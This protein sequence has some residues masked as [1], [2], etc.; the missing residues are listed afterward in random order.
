MKPIPTSEARTSNLE[1]PVTRHHRRLY[2]GWVMVLTLSLTETTSWGI[3][4]YAFAVFLTPMGAEMGWSVAE[5]TG[6]YSLALLL[7]GVAG[8]PVGRWLDRHGPRALMTVGSI[9]ATLLVLAW[10]AVDSLWMFY[11]IWMGIGVTMAAVLYEPAFVVVAT[12]FVRGRGRAL[13]VL[14]FLA[15]LASV[16]Y[17]P[18]ANGLVQ[19][20]G[21]REALVIL[22][23]ILGI[24]TIPLHALVL[25]RSPQTLGLLPDGALTVPQ[26]RTGASAERSATVREAVRSAAF[27]WLNSAFILATLATMTLTVHLI[28]YLLMRD[29]SAGFAASAAGAVGLLALPGRLIFTPLGGRVPRQIVTAAIF[30]L[31]TASLLVLLLVPTTTGV[32]IFVILFG[33]GFGAITPAR[34]ALVS[35]LYG[36]ANY[37][38]INSIVSLCLTLSRAVAPV[39]A[40]LLFILLDSYTPVLW[41]AVTVSALA[42]VA[43]LRARGNR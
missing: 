24:G 26:P 34:A 33:A 38:S 14:T 21:W 29:F 11:L 18:L 35:D 22:A 25:R 16:I 19:R 39:G 12:W 17:I 20:Y 31:Q 27:W 32:V 5:M 42:S 9:A 13:T 30:A 2:Y 23:I 1:P 10:A 7:S 41:T 8:I 36:T 6:A 37:G 15:G 43:A 4:Y 3:L 40:G 28:P